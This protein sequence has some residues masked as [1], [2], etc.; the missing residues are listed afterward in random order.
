MVIIIKGL[1]VVK[2]DFSDPI[3]SF[4]ETR[5]CHRLALLLGSRYFKDCWHLKTREAE[6]W[7]SKKH[8]LNSRRKVIWYVTVF[9]GSMYT[10]WSQSCSHFGSAPYLDPYYFGCALQW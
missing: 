2:F 4:D 3:F 9:D 8:T 5:D 10:L 1:Q 6:R 7:L